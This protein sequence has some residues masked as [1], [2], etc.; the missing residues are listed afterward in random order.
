[1]RLSLDW[2]RLLQDF[3]NVRIASSGN[4]NLKLFARDASDWIY[5]AI[6][7]VKQKVLQKPL[8]EKTVLDTWQPDQ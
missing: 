5:A 6:K 7:P 3:L 4:D 8:T 2:E 1:M